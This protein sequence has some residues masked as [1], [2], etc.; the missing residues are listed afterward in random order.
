MS[1]D[2]EARVR[3]LA[4]WRGEIEVAP[5]PGG[6]SNASFRVRDAEGVWVAR[7]GRD[8]PFHHVFRDR[9]AA[10]SR[11]AQA[12]GFAPSVRYSGDGALVSA[13]VPGRTLDAEAVRADLERV[14]ALVAAV[15]A[16]MPKR[17]RGPAATFWVFHVVRDY[18]DTLRAGK[19]PFAGE[20]PRLAPLVD[21]LEAA[22]VPTRLV[23]GHHDLLPANLIDDGARLWLIDWE[24]A[25]FG[26]PLFDLANLADNAGFSRAEERRLLEVYFGRALDAGLLGAFAAMKVASAL[27]ETLWAFVSELHL[28]APGADYAAYGRDCLAR[29]EAALGAYREGGL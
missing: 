2:A 22:Q 8:F 1:E 5:L 15:H 6:L 4:C 28:A 21:E 18:L 17:V 26:T 25:G 7:I 27:R 23:F 12:A 29:F 10:A 16:E 13:F 11:A 3:A 19:H 14:A 9:E 20:A 24:Y